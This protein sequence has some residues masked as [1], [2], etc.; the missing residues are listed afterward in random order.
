MVVV[1]LDVGVDAQRAGT[2][3]EHVELTEPLEV[4]H[5]LVHGLQGDRRHVEPGAVVERL[6]RRVGG[7]G[8]QQPEDRLAL[9]GD[10][11]AAG[12]EQIGELGNALHDVEHLINNRCRVGTVHRRVSVRPPCEHAGVLLIGDV[13][14]NAARVAPDAVAATL[15]DDAWTFGAL[16]EAANRLAQG[17]IGAGIEPGDRVLWWS[18]TA[19]EALPVFAALAKLGAVFAPLNAR[20]SVD[21]VRAVAEYA[22]PRLLLAGAS[23]RDVAV[24][25]ADATGI[26]Y[27]DQ[28]EPGAN[29]APAP[30]SERAIDER[31]PH[32]IFFTSGS[33]GTPKGV[34]LSHRANW[35]RT[36]PGATTTTGGRGTVCMFPLF[37]MAG[38]TIA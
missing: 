13:F 31:D 10:A 12:A 21:E 19:L 16:D 3:V 32:V 25:L 17:L 14:A 38:W 20:A 4:V 2:E 1:V 30:A 9:R 8:L 27:L 29:V 24:A 36:Y 35:L 5:G 23:H 15:D 28:V 7:V 6:H 11:Q 26:Q 37:H 22:R 33:T 18:D 34:V